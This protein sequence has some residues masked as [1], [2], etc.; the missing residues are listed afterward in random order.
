MTKTQGISFINKSHGAV[1]LNTRNTTFAKISSSRPAWWMNIKMTNFEKDWNIL[2]ADEKE[3]KWIFIPADTFKDTHDHFRIWE[4]KKAV[5]I[6]ISSDK[7]DR[8]LKDVSS[9]G[10]EV[11][12][13]PFLKK[14]ISL[15]QD[16]KIEEGEFIRNK[17]GSEKSL[18][19]LTHQ[20]ILTEGQKGIS[21]QNLF[22]H[23]L[24]G[25]K[26]IIL[27]DPYIRLQHQFQNLLEFCVMLGNNK[28]IEEKL[29]IEVISWNTKEFLE[30][31]R[32]SFDELTTSVAELGIDLTFKFEKHHD[33]F[34]EADNGL[35][36]ILGRG[37][38]IFEKTVGRF[39]V[40]EVDQ[41]W[42]KCKACEITYVKK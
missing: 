24:K 26:K 17:K 15:P 38:D 27:Q 16:V 2:L 34:I 42:R 18:E 9:G 3:L 25:S 5:D 7:N 4:A 6:Y 32:S 33:R 21:Y 14:I 1:K 22:A 30:H 41:T 23:R 37:L 40:G 35:K 28:I 11:N 39:S 20:K 29:E 8:Y 10:S 19:T 12:F 36:I 31:S 13:K